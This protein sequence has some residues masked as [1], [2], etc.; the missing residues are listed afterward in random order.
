MALPKK[1]KPSIYKFND[2]LKKLCIFAGWDCVSIPPEDDGKLKLEK[3]RLVEKRE[4]INV[5]KNISIPVKP[6]QEGKNNEEMVKI[7]ESEF[8]SGQM[9][10]LLILMGLIQFHVSDNSILI[11][12]EFLVNFTYLEGNEVLKNVIEYFRKNNY[13]GKEKKYKL[14]I[15]I[16]HDLSFDY[17]EKF[18]GRLDD[19]SV[20]I[21]GIEKDEE[22]Q[23]KKNQKANTLDFQ[24]LIVHKIS[25]VEFSRKSK[26][27]E[28]G[29]DIRDKFFKE[30]DDSYK[31]RAL[32]AEECKLN[33][34]FSDEKY[35]YDIDIKKNN[36]AL[37]EENYKEKLFEGD[38]SLP[39]KKNCFIVLTGFSGCGK[40]TLCKLFVDTNIASDGKKTFRYFPDR[41]LSS[42]SEDSQ[43]YIGDDLLNMYNYYDGVNNL[44]DCID[45][46]KELIDKVN[47]FEDKKKID[48]DDLDYFLSRKIFDLSGGQQQRYLFIRLMLSCIQYNKKNKSPELFIFDES[49]ASLD[50]ITKNKIIAFLL[51]VILS[52]NGATILFISHDL[53]DISVIYKTL[54]ANVGDE[55]I[56]SVFEHYEMLDG[57]LFKV[58]ESFTD[59]CK[60]IEKGNVYFSLRDK[61]KITLKLN[62]AQDRECNNES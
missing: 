26:S 31:K 30:F 27:E 15:F 40:S 24:K 44:N 28:W 57:N 46:I 9:Q 3:L 51:K 48:N 47:Y 16:L 42:V 55:K 29:N 34:K 53:R 62:K 59:Y 49:I 22:Y 11:G 20:Q 25:A 61:K 33:I 43:V 12:D 18:I 37:Y 1:Q 10:R 4:Y 6:I 2:L 36:Y 32:T 5:D 58:E 45:D 21:I 38:I 8:S 35:P 14:A 60:N 39:L 17:L 13:N 41:S 56:S 23:C 52:E 50:C 19:D 7:Y 54:Q